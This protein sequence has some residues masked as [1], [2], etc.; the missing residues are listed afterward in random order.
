MIDMIERGL[1][2]EIQ[3]RDVAREAKVSAALIIRYFGSKSD[4]QF[5]A[6]ST[7]IVE[8]SNPQLRAK[9]SRGAFKSPD[10]LAKFLLAADLE[11]AYRTVSMLEMS[12]RGRPEQEARWS[13]TQQPRRDILHRLVS[14]EAPKAKPD[15]V[16]AACRFIDLAYND[17]LRAALV[18]GWTL[19]Q[20]LDRFRPAR[21]AVLA[22]LR[23]GAFAA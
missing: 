7:R 10:D 6:L 21:D 2:H 5:E 3:L 12:W 15:Q 18:H 14:V 16:T 8:T 19:S 23:S 22:A 20:A 4:L 1:G 17:V 9:D 13:A 11:S